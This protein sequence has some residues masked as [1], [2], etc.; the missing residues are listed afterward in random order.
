MKEHTRIDLLGRC[1]EKI[2]SNML[3]SEGMIIEESVD[4]FDSSKDMIAYYNDSEYTI[5]VK[6]QVPFITKNSFTIRPNQLNKCI[7][8]DR[9]F[10]VA[11]PSLNQYRYEGWIFLVNKTFIHKKYKTK[12][13]LDM[14]LIPIDQDAVVPIKK[15]S[16]KDF[17]QLR[18][19]A[20]KNY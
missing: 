18:K 3:S 19:F 20:C 10:Y 5:E 16:D 7:S 14:I 2:I 15:V 9:L 6:T 17:E 1:G 12:N 13:G 8:V 4:P 11:A